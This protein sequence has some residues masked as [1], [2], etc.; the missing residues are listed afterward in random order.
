MSRHA[1]SQP[2]SHPS[3]H[4]HSSSRSTPAPPTRRPHA[5]RRRR[6]GLWLGLAL[7]LAIGCQ[8]EGARAEG[9]AP[10]DPAIRAIDAFIA[11]HPVDKQNPRWRTQLTKPPR[12]EFAKDRKYYWKLQTNL[13]DMKFRLFD[14]VAPMHVSS[15]IYLTRLGFYDS[16]KF[17]RVIAGFM[18]QGGDP[19]GNGRGNPG[20]RY[21][22]EFSP[23]VR[24]DGPG[25]LSMANAG[26]GTDGSQFF[27]TFKATPHLNDKHTVF[28]K[29]EPGKSLETIRKMEALAP[30]PPSR[31]STPTRP[32]TIERATI[33]IE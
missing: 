24:H 11:E 28:G 33:V 14:D 16:L 31:S 27:I 8:E 21:A 13:G 15:T 29:V 9:E 7:A 6:V 2:T 3:S 32:I 1:L 10:S 4:S 12:V 23:K 25:I 5:P 19:L 20:F 30:P 17:H 26:P 18:A 22:G